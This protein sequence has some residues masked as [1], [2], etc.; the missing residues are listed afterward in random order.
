MDAELKARLDAID[1]RLEATH[2]SAEKARKYLL[3]I[4]VIT[5]A[6]IVLPA[7]GLVFAIPTFLS[8]YGAIGGI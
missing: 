2:V 4:T 8:T 5:I 7:I 1:A 3:V 6:A